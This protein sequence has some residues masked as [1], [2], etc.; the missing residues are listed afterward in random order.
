MAILTGS[1]KD[2]EEGR[3][4]LKSYGSGVEFKYLSFRLM[5]Y[6]RERLEQDSNPAAIVI[7]ASQE[8][9]RARR[10]GE[11]FNAKLYLIRKLYDKDYGKDE[12]KGLFE[13]IDWVLQLN[14]EEEK[15]VWEEIQKFEEVKKMPYVTS[16]ERIGIKIGKEEGRKEGMEIGMEK[17]RYTELVRMVRNVLMEKWGRE[18]EGLIAFVDQAPADILEQVIIQIVRGNKDKVQ[19]L[20]N[21]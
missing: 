2:R 7:L 6:D 1:E 5:D 10:K 15:L 19:A 13:F 9:E 14:D 3:Y 12:I 8:R 16:V 21:C 18:V 4:E 17:G 11:K 20:L